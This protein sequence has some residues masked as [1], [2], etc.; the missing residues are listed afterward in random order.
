MILPFL[1]TYWGADIWART[2]D[3]V[4]LYA[5]GQ[6]SRNEKYIQTSTDDRNLHFPGNYV[7][8]CRIGDVVAYVA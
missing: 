5:L 6:N 8:R 3:N 2:C 7:N 4:P 1:S